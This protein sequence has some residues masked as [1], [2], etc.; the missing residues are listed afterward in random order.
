MQSDRSWQF[1]YMH[2]HANTYDL[3]MLPKL[4]WIYAVLLALKD[5]ILNYVTIKRQGMHTKCIHTLIPC[6]F[7]C[8]EDKTI[9]YCVH[10][11]NTIMNY[12]PQKPRPKHHLH[13]YPVLCVAFNQL[14]LYQPLWHYT[15]I[16]TFIYL[17]VFFV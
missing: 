11:K 10:F 15:C 2:M 13:G 8:Y 17:M 1:L 12:R 14:I 3:Y 4:A 5:Q 6:K 9:A 16:H 7:L